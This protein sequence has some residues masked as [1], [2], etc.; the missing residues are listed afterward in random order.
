MPG[1]VSK[2]QQS[3][4]VSSRV[5]S[6]Y[7]PQSPG[8]GGSSAR[9]HACQRFLTGI[10]RD[11]REPRSRQHQGDTST[12]KSP[13]SRG[14]ALGSCGAAQRATA[15][16][17]PPGVVEMEQFIMDFRGNIEEST[18]TS[19]NFEQSAME[20]SGV[21][22][23]QTFIL[24]EVDFGSFAKGRSKSRRLT[25]LVMKFNSLVVASSFTLY[26]CIARP[27]SILLMSPVAMVKSHHH[28]ALGKARRK[29]LRATIGLA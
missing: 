6:L 23:P 25:P 4:R 2:A 12:E 3:T 5:G 21:Y 11:H 9:C 15:R 14:A 7:F 26:S 27:T 8:A 22:C 10:R 29:R 13:R 1:C 18:T 28:G 20:S 24:K 19:W 16:H 17:P